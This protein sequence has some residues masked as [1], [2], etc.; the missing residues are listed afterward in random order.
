MGRDPK[1]ATAPGRAHPTLPHSARP[2]CPG[3]G[4][5]M[6]VAEGP[7]WPGAFTTVSRARSTWVSPRTSLRCSELGRGEN[8][9]VP[10]T[11]PI[12]NP[13][14]KLAMPTQFWVQSRP[15]HMFCDHSPHFLMG[16]SVLTVPLYHS[17]VRGPSQAFLKPPTLPFV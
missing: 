1:P 16:Y 14:L 12:I 13:V 11:L 2:R 6:S 4:R 8:P 3:S 17:P 15:I 9:T 7:A 10:R 5:R